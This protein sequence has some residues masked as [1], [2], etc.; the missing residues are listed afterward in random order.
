M[1][2]CNVEMFKRMFDHSLENEQYYLKLT[3]RGSKAELDAVL[4]KVVKQV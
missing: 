1:R 4:K 3:L 2:V